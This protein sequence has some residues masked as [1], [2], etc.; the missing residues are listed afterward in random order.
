M[1]ESHHQC[2]QGSSSKQSPCV[3]T[4]ALTASVFPPPLQPGSPRQKHFKAPVLCGT[5]EAGDSPVTYPGHTVRPAWRSP[6]FLFSFMLSYCCA[7]F[8]FFHRPDRQ[9][10]SCSKSPPPPPPVTWL[11]PDEGAALLLAAYCGRDKMRTHP[12]L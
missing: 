3:E 6:W 2:H 5:Q 10:P 4:R 7:V 1:E 8:C 12:G 11:C 9:G